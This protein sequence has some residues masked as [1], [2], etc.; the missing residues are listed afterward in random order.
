MFAMLHQLKFR[1]IIPKLT[2]LVLNIF[3]RQ[4]KKKKKKK[5][6]GLENNN[7]APIQKKKYHHIKEKLE[8]NIPT[9]SLIIINMSI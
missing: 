9:R 2:T 6:T 8:T 7:L 5:K 1:I 3:S 4:D